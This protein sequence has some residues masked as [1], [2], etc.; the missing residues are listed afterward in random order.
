MSK[1]AHLVRSEIETALEKLVEH[2]REELHLR[3]HRDQEKTAHS[4]HG[5]DMSE[6]LTNASSVDRYAREILNLHAKE[7]PNLRP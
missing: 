7:L 3:R 5:H 1:E 2:A 4:Q 6:L